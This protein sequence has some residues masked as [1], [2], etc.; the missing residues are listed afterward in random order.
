MKVLPQKR[1][2]WL[3]TALMPLFAA[4]GLLA[5]EQQF[6]DFNCALTP[7]DTWQVT[8]NLPPKRGVLAQYRNAA[9]TRLIVL[10]IEDRKL[11]G[12]MDEATVLGF[13]GGFRL[14][15]GGERTSWKFIDVAGIK[16]YERK[17]SMLTHGKRASTLGRLVPAE[18]RFYWLEAFRFDGEADEAPEI[19]RAL[20]GFRF[21][22]P[23]VQVYAPSGSAAFQFGQKMGYLTAMLATVFAVVAVTVAV[24]MGVWRSNRMSQARRAS[25]PPPLP[26]STP[27]PLPPNHC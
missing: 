3:A 1:I 9:K 14:S 17:G 10:M 11:P 23:P 12:P 24:I 16:S 7:P 4:A 6:A 8:T 2:R 13:E 22:R 25:G 21:L 18:G 19:Q 27:P 26:T 15:G 20:D 5:Q